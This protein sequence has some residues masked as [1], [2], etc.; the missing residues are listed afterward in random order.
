MKVDK[1][2]EKKNVQESIPTL[3]I[4]SDRVLLAQSLADLQTILNPEGSSLQSIPNED[5]LFHACQ[6]VGDSLNLTFIRSKTTEESKEQN[7]EQLCMNSRIY[8]RRISLLG[9]WWKHQSYPF[10]SF[11]GKEEIPVAV[12]S[13]HGTKPLFFNPSNG[14]STTL[15]QMNAIEFSSYGYQFYR[16]FKEPTLT[17]RTIWDF[18]IGSRSREWITFLFLVLCTTLANLSFPIFTSFLFDEMIPNRNEHQLWQLAFGAGLIAFSTLIFNFG[19]EAMILRI[20]SLSD[21]DLEMAVWQRLIQ[22]PLSFFRRHNLY[23]LFTFTGA[24]ASIRKLLVSHA[25]EVIFNAFFALFYVCLMLY[26]SWTLSLIALSLL[27]I[28]I[29]AIALPVYFAIQYGRQLLEKQ[30]QASN[31]MLEIVQ[32]LTKVRLAGAEAR[33]FNRW[34]R[35]FSQMAKMDLHILFLNL[36][37]AVFNVFWSNASTWVLYLFIVLL[38]IDEHSAAGFSGSSLTI[39]GFMAFL[40]IFNLL[41]HSLTELGSTLL[42]IA[43]VIP[44]W[45]K[46]KSFSEAQPEESSIKPRPELLKGEVRIQHLTFRYQQ[47]LPPILDDISLIIQPGEKVAFVGE[48]GAG[49]TT[50]LKLLLGFEKADR[51]SIYYDQQ[52]MRGLNL[53][54]LRRQL[55]VVLQSGAL[56][57]GTLLENVRCGRKYERDE[58]IQTLHLIGAEWLIED[59]P[60]G[61]NTLITNRGLSFSGGQRQLILLARAILGNPSILI[62]D[63]ATSSLDNHKQSIVDRHLRHLPMTQIIVAQRLDTIRYVDRIYVIHQ[64][65]IAESG[66]FDALAH[67]PGIFSDLLLKSNSSIIINGEKNGINRRG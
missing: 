17:A 7:V 39:G 27:T 65:K 3:H 35:S 23:D 45:E 22:L 26:Y 59:L 67:K 12:I 14:V 31:K 48:S 16:Q 61:I 15:N 58:V 42:H 20:E 6:K 43:G 1:G 66:T 8:Y 36:K 19:R 5:L 40:S 25:I 21:H 37:S 18:M 10:V 47:S 32:A 38:F 60:M 9:N 30:I 64:G 46:T 49:K 11:Y 44:L 50:L 28:E 56:F 52:D 55:G 29:L 33:M 41:S 24:I 53:Q 2:S 63:E 51:G 13:A 4:Q 54:A 62:L 34:E 57:D